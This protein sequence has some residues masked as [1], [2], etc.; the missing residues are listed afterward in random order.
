M[1]HFVF[2]IGLSAVLALGGGCSKEARKARYLESGEKYFAANDFVKAEV[3][4]LNAF[5]LDPTDK[6]LPGRLGVIYFDQGRLE[7]AYAFLYRANEI[8]P[9]STNIALPLASI[10]SV[11][12]Q[13]AKARE[14]LAP[15]L[16]RE[17]GHAEAV[18]LLA[19]A[20]KTPADRKQLREQIQAWRQKPGDK[21][22]YHVA[23]GLLANRDNDMRTGEA[24]A[25]QALAMDPKLATAHLALGLLHWRKNELVDAERELRAALQFS[26]PRSSRRM[27]LVTFFQKNGRLAEAKKQLE[28]IVKATPDYLP[29]LSSLGEMQLTDKELDA[30]SATLNR[31]RSLEALNYETGLLEARLRFAQ[32]KI[33]D[34]IQIYERL[35]TKNPKSAE[36]NH[37]AAVAYLVGKNPNRALACL[38]QAVSL[39]TNLY[40]PSILLAGL[41]GQQRDFT[42]SISMLLDIIKKRPNDEQAYYLLA[43]AYRS[44]GDLED[45]LRTYRALARAFP[46]NPQAS[47]SMGMILREQNKPAEARAAFQQALAISTNLFAAFNQLVE[48]DVVEGNVTNA[49]QQVQTAVERNPKAPELRYLEARIHTV[50]GDTAQAEVALRK[51]L[52]LAPDYREARLALAQIFITTQKPDWALEELG[53]VVAKNPRDVEALLMMGV[54]YEAQGKYPK[55][56]EKYE[57]LLAVNPQTSAAL[58]NLAYVYAVHLKQPDK[59]Y[60]FAQKGRQLMPD[61][62]SVADTLGWVTYLRGDYAAALPLLQ[63]SAARMPGEAEVQ[64]HL[65]MTDYMLGQEAA[66]RTALQAAVAG[67]K[68]YIGKDQARQKL[69]I[70]G[71]QSSLPAAEVMQAL[72]KA[73]VQDPNDLATLL[74]LGALYEQNGQLEKAQSISEQALKLNPKAVRAMLVLARLHGAR[75]D[76]APRALEYAKAAR[77]AAPGDPEVAY[78]AGRATFQAGHHEWAYSILQESSRKQ[79]GNPDLLYDLAWAAYSVGKV[80]EAESAMQAAVRSGTNFTRVEAAKRFL[81]MTALGRNPAGIAQARD[82]VSAV[83]KADP[84]YAPALMVAALAWEASGGYAEARK[85]YEQVLAHYPQFLPAMRNLALVYVN[86]L[87]DTQNG[88]EL[89]RKAR[90]GFPGDVEVANALGKAAYR[91]GEFPYASQLLKEVVQKNGAD[92]ETYFCL[93]LSQRQQKQPKESAASLQQALAMNL[94]AKLAEEAKRVMAELNKAK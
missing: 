70:M 46:K 74:K 19:E 15:L 14:V 91:R 18:E 57:A 52:E 23:L 27:I 76:G 87:E 31:A 24:E 10:Y 93:G 51:S 81:E 50:K 42:T 45:A 83:L 69:V 86:H 32:G 3:E 61:D 49:L 1:K 28:E 22:S 88:Y 2:L 85:N 60:V 77:A 36:L 26:P 66:A 11:S 84:A 65:G 67:T 5:R 75:P 58:N 34:S 64:Y 7:R 82:R 41:K 20:A 9:G 6:V 43:N 89:A 30:C 35:L 54:L 17:P 59:G 13:G 90:L 56:A 79:A 68:E 47:L 44:S 40:E 78:A 73:L 29:A 48:M 8:T 38:Q 62:P 33:A 39:N 92:A 55:A 4:F 12:G 21:A 53:K 37:Q 63:E 94:N 71:G 72:E 25:R 80:T 16:A